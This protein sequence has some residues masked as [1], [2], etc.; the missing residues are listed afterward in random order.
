MSKNNTTPIRRK[1][2]EDWWIRLANFNVCNI[3]EIENI[4]I[5]RNRLKIVYVRQ[6]LICSII[7]E[8]LH[9]RTRIQNKSKYEI[10][11]TSCTKARFYK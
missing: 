1:I 10:E 11:R 4:I 5:L 8:K 7:A 9:T 2:S 3:S 6:N